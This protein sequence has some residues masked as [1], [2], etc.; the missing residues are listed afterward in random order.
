MDYTVHGV[1]KSQ[2][3]LSNFTFPWC[4]KWLRLR[5]PNAEG[6]GLIPG[7]GIRSHMLQLRPR[8]DK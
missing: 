7:Q 8:A 6:P 5:A 2:T 4:S 3:Q 1:A